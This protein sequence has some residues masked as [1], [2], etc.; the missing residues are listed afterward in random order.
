MWSLSNIC[1][2][3]K[4]SAAPYA[5]V[6]QVIDVFGKGNFFTILYVNDSTASVSNSVRM[7]SA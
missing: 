2:A 6:R 3:G 7:A 4:N 5:E 1:S